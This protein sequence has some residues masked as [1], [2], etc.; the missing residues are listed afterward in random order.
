MVLVFSNLNQNPASLFQIRLKV[1]ISGRT[2]GFLTKTL[3]QKLRQLFYHRKDD[4]K[5]DSIDDVAHEPDGYK[6]VGQENR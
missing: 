4:Q 5:D 2:A 3:P 6:I 1:R